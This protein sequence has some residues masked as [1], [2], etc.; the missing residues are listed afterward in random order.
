MRNL[1][2]VALLAIVACSDAGG[3]TAQL[4]P[5]SF[6]L[7]AGAAQ[8]DTVGRELKDMIALRVLATDGETAVPNYPITW[9]PLD[10]GEVFAVVVYSG[11]DGVARQRWTLG[12]RA[13]T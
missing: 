2:L 11:T 13:G 4:V 1:P 7:V 6:A 10:G 3:P 12:T 8:T 5:A 9:T